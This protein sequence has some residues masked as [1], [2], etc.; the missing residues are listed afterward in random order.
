MVPPRHRFTRRGLLAFFGA[1]FASA[2]LPHP[3]SAAETP[4]D[5]KRDANWTVSFDDT[6]D[7]PS[8]F[9]LN[10][11]KI[12]SGGD[13]TQTLRLPQN[14]VLADGTLRLELGSNPDAND[15]RFRFTGGYVESADFRQRYGYFECEMTIALEAGVNNA[16]WLVSDPR[17]QAA[18]DFELDVAE[19]KFP[20]VV[21]SSVRLW[22]PTR[23][24]HAKVF[25]A[26]VSLAAA[27][28]R[29]A[30]LWGPKQITFF[31][32]DM[33]FFTVQNDFAHT[34]AVLRLSN[35]VADFAGP[36]DGEVT[37]A[38]TVIGRVRVLQNSDWASLASPTGR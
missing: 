38:A 3:S 10:W 35:A 36:N 23:Q 19:V 27:S 31:F 16:F 17:T 15:H 26:P 28:H 30:M 9:A 13:Q 34:P 29:Y 5:L 8:R 11:R 6:F 2:A 37:G 14:D 32:D 12:K 18:Q 7:D 25:H 1:S 33:A 24:V 22:R 20:T 4:P 21:Q